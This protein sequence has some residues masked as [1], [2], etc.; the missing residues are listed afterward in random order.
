MKHTA[1]DLPPRRF[2]TEER[3]EAGYTLVDGCWHKDGQPICS[4]PHPEGYMRVVD[5]G[6]LVRSPAPPVCGVRATVKM[7][8][9]GRYYCDFHAPKKGERIAAEARR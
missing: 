5:G 8:R 9:S 4:R 7:V 6:R 1:A 3:A 2:T